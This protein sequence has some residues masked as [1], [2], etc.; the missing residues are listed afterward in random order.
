M[1]KCKKGVVSTVKSS[2]K[3]AFRDY[4]GHGRGFLKDAEIILDSEDIE[5][6]VTAIPELCFHAIENFAKGLLLKK[7]GRL[8]GG[9]GITLDLFNENFVKDGEMNDRMYT[10]YAEVR[11]SRNAASYQFTKISD[12]KA[13]EI[14]E[15]TREFE[16]A[17]LA[18][19]RS[20]GWLHG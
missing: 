8:T 6:D 7:I 20:R 3:P 10:V 13:A 19:A 4:I 12:L 15:K 17:A 9:H 11:S 18:Y 5:K 1:Q 14:V 16:D 2:K